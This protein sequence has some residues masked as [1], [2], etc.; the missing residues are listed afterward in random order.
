M[1]LERHLKTVGVNYSGSD[2]EKTIWK[3]KLKPIPT[4][5]VQQNTFEMDEGGPV[6]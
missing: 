1:W 5:I 2:V 3:K 6:R 4:Y